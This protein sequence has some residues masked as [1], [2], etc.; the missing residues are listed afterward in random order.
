MILHKNSELNSI[1]NPN[2]LL[3][4]QLIIYN[5]MAESKDINRIKVMLAEKKAHE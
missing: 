4:S 2:F 5:I 3:L 1:Y